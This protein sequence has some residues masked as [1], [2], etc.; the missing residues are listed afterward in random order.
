MTKTI[1]VVKKL[2][3]FGRSGRKNCRDYKVII[4]KRK[5]SQLQFPDILRIVPDTKQVEKIDFFVRP[6]VVLKVLQEIKLAVIIVSSKKITTA[7]KE[8]VGILARRRLLVKWRYVYGYEKRK[9]AG[10]R[11]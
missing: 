4:I 3:F 5:H 6:V 10:N 8:S 9:S 7:L 2:K 1:F 11:S